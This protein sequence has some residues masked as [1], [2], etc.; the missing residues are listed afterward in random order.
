DS[1]LKFV[2]PLK[3]RVRRRDSSLRFRLASLVCSLGMRLHS[4]I[5]YLEFRSKFR[6]RLNYA[7]IL[8]VTLVDS[9]PAATGESRVRGQRSHRDVNCDLARNTTV[10]SD[11]LTRNCRGLFDNLENRAD[12]NT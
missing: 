10:S 4:F 11:V 5:K 3:P 9:S 7:V 2:F 8:A 6:P 12:T 1:G